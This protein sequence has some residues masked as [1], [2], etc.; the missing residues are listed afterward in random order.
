MIPPLIN[1]SIAPLILIVLVWLVRRVRLWAL[2]I[3]ETIETMPGGFPRIT[4]DL[5]SQMI[6]AGQSVMG[7]VAAAAMLSLGYLWL[8][9][10]LGQFPYS[11]AWGEELS[12]FLVK[13]FLNFGSGAFSAVPAFLPS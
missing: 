2:K 5:R 4:G 6:Q 9:F 12:Q 11:A 8:V 13:L 3:L 10:S 7:I 1:V